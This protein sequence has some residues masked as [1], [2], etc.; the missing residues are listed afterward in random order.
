MTY[1]TANGT[2]SFEGQ[3]TAPLV[4]PPQE[5]VREGFRILTD[6]SPIANHRYRSG[7]VTT[8]QQ[9]RRAIP[10]SQPQPTKTRGATIAVREHV[11]RLLRNCQQISHDLLTSDDPI[12]SA[13]L[14]GRLTNNL[15]E[16]WEHRKSREADWIE[17]LNVMQIA[18]PAE[19]FEFLPKDKRQALVRIFSEG[20]LSRTVGPIEVGRSLKL[21]T[22]AGFNIW[23]GFTDDNERS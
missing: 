21:L 17:I 1:I 8:D 14:G 7:L 15:H 22:D 20:L 9:I 11:A 3:E 13:L 5:P 19:E 16:L 6:T 10:A 4:P 23:R 18:V 12:E 2:G